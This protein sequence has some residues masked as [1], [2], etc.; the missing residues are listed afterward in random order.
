MRRALRRLED[1]ESRAPGQVSVREPAVGH[2][3][4][5]EIGEVHRRVR[6]RPAAIVHVAGMHRE[7]RGF[8]RV[9]VLRQPDVGLK[10]KPAEAGELRLEVFTRVGKDRDRQLVRAEAK[11]LGLHSVDRLDELGLDRAGDLGG[12][13]HLGKAA[14]C[15]LGDR[16]AVHGRETVRDDDVRRGVDPVEKAGQRR[17]REA[18]DEE[19]GREPRCA[20]PLEDPD[21]AVLDLER[22]RCCI[23]G[24]KCH[25]PARLRRENAARQ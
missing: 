21:H 3:Q 7:E 18:R 6:H 5:R 4:G 20:G 24:E 16:G 9:P 25:L 10:R 8:R 1:G 17:H 14:K 22:H 15:A 12:G 23:L 19:D 13:A 11:P 2:V